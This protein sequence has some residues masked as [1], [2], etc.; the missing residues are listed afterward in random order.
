MVMEM[1]D[2]CLE[3]EM[4]AKAETVSNSAARI[5]THTLKD[6]E[7]ASWSCRRTDVKCEGG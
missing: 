5:G 4:E 2:G 3:M 6:G 7:R 1:D